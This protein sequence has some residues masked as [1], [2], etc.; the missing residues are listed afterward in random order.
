M[1]DG[2]RTRVDFPEGSKF[3]GHIIVET[4]SERKEFFPLTNELL[5]SPPR[6]EEAQQRLMHL[7]ERG[8]KGNVVFSTAPGQRV[9]GQSTQQLVVSDRQGNVLQRLY[10][11]PRTG[12]LLKRDVFDP[13]GARIASFEFTEIDLNPPP[14]DRSMFRFERRGVKVV[15]P[16]DEL[17][18]IATKNR[19]MPYSLPLSSGY[20]LDEVRLMRPHGEDVLTQTY[21]SPHGKV[22]LFEVRSALSPEKLKG[23]ARGDLHF[24]SWQSGAYTFVLMG[25]LD[26][27]EL[28]RLAQVAL[29]GTR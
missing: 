15:T 18:T 24:S 14:F 11:E 13:G 22:S 10:I 16:Y 9:A 12:V 7:A 25:S 20:R 23:F 17:R 19:F 3:Q 4:R 2:E 6:H 5:I 1:R 28:D 8:A 27:A 26:Q 21:V 29:A